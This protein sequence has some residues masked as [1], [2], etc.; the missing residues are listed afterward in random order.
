M[1]YWRNVCVT[2]NC[3]ESTGVYAQTYT[4]T[5]THFTHV[6]THSY[7]R[8]HTCAH[9]RKHTHTH[10]NTH[11][12]THTNTYTHTHVNT[13]ALANARSH[14][15]D[16]QARIFARKCARARAIINLCITQ[17][18]THTHIAQNTLNHAHIFRHT[19]TQIHEYGQHSYTLHL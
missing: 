7:T 10:A 19:N 6:H 13:R 9:A 5:R 2:Q 15:Y 11:T 3:G 14:I 12:H 8:T 4:R 18:R 17:L 16:T 1:W